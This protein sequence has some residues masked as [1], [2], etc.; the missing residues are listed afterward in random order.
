MAEVSLVKRQ[1]LRFLRDTARRMRELAE[2]EL[3]N[4]RRSEMLRLAGEIEGEADDL[5]MTSERDRH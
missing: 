4:N 5:E 1:Q 3:P 2:S